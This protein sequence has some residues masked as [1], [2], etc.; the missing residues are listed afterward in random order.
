MSKV[1]VDNILTFVECPMKL[2][3]KSSAVPDLEDRFNKSMQYTFDY[4]FRQCM[5]RVKTY[6]KDLRRFFNTSYNSD[7]KIYNDKGFVH[8]DSYLY[9]AVELI[10]NFEATFSKELK[11]L[12]EVVN[13]D[14]EFCVECECGK[15]YVNGNTNVIF[16]NNKNYI[17]VQYMTGKPVLTELD[18]RYNMEQSIYMYAVSKQY[19]NINHPKMFLYYPQ[20]N[21]FQQVH[22]YK[23]EIN[24]IG[25]TICTVADALDKNLVWPINNQ[26]TCCMCKYVSACKGR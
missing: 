15:H 10:D 18:L 11:N 20:F 26:D 19:K 4:Y 9:K 14:D 16:E 8:R 3:W 22:R 7:E 6:N 23:H 12:G 13:V 1:T 24:M 2:V 21:M 5:S 17:I 25:K